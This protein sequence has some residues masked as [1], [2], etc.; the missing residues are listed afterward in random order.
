M[1][2]SVAEALDVL[3]LSAEQA[4]SRPILRQTY[5]AA[6]LKHHPD[7]NPGVADAAVATGTAP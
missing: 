6:V 5:R 4:F 7:K 2:L 3:G 1:A